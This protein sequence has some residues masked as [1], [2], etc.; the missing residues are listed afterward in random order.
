[1]RTALLLS[2]AMLSCQPGS[3]DATQD[4]NNP[5]TMKPGDKPPILIDPLIFPVGNSRAD[6]Q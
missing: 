2:L 1:M 3:T 5:D 4:P 6:S